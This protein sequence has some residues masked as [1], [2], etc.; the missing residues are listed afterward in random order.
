MDI[1]GVKCSRVKKGTDDIQKQA[2]RIEM[3][4]TRG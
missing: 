1:G 2:V 3:V 4:K